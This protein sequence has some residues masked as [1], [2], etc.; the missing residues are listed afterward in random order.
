MPSLAG[1]VD[2]ALLPS[3]LLGAPKEAGAGTL[4]SQQRESLRARFARLELVFCAEDVHHRQRVR[5]GTAPHD[6]EHR[7]QHATA[8]HSQALHAI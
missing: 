7:R 5:G 6:P 2:G 4:Q 1:V 3:V 8:V